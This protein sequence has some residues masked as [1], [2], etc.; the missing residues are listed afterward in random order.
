MNERQKDHIKVQGG[1]FLVAAVFLSI[2]EICT[3]T[4]IDPFFI[5]S[6]SRIAVNLGKELTDKGFYYDLYISSVE[7]LVGYVVGAAAGIVTGVLLARWELIARI[8]DPFL[9]ALN[10]IPRMALAPLLIIWFGIDMMSKIV[11]AGM[12]VFFVTFFNTIGGIRSVDNRLCEVSRVLGCNEWQVFT[13]VML[14]SAS[15]WIITGLKMSLPFALIGVIVGEFM[16]ASA[17]IGYR[18][19]MFTT[20]YNITGA[21]TVILLIMVLMTLLNEIMN[22]FEEKLLRWRPTTGRV[23]EPQ[24][25]R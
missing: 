8:M 3:L 1:R 17:G 22:R 20:T 16:A 7:L 4:V 25:V 24:G 13:K 14:P 5:S 10:S 12:M 9:I 21:M 23:P 15:S 18:L 6:P 2:W 11:L 19:N